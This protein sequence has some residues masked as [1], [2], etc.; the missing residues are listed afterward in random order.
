MTDNQLKMMQ[1]RNYQ[2]MPLGAKIRRSE[3]LIR[4]A[5]E[6]FDDMLYIALSGGKDS[7]VLA[8]IVWSIDKTI[9]AIFCD[10]GNELDS[11][12]A[13]IGKMINDGLPITII[14][15]KMTF[16]EVIKKY[17]YPVLS[18]NITMGIDRFIKTKSMRQKILRAFGGINPTSG[19]KQRASIPKKWHYLLKMVLDGELRTTNKCCGILKINP[20][21]PY[22]KK[23][24]RKPFVG[25]MAGESVNRLESYLKLGCNAFE[26][27]GVSRPLMFWTEQDIL[28]YHK[29]KNLPMAAAYG[30]IENKRGELRCSG[31]QRTGC[32]FCLFGVH[33]EKGEN[34]IQRLARVEPESYKHAIEDL[35]YDK[36][37]DTLGVDWRP[38]QKPDVQQDLFDESY[39]VDVD[40]L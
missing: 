4:Q 18:K 13:H 25:T 9:P 7:C 24:G 21:K 27:D 5:L 33:L 36:V 1:L 38:Y 22:A 32:K 14:K 15:P 28:Q 20:T 30:E 35:G 40:E 26:G 3:M 10:T 2:A 8:D 17:G 31:D 19:K 23:T 16:D 37:M 34:R 12:V 11:V 39:D 6:H 29:E